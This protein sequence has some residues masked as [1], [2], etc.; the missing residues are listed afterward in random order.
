VGEPHPDP[1]RRRTPPPV[2]R[3]DG[4]LEGEVLTFDRFGNAITNLVP[5]RPMPHGATV[6]TMGQVIPLV[7]TYGDVAPG[8][9]LALVGSS[10]L[11]ELAVRNGSA[12]LRFGMARGQGVVLVAAGVAAS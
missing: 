11:V 7:R 1:V 3:G 4:T 6:E 9:P 10:G 2:R 5:A 8:A 12:A